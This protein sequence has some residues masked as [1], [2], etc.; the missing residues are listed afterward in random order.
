VAG[1]EPATE[2]TLVFTT[3]NF[4]SICA[5]KSSSSEPL[6]KPTPENPSF[7]RAGSVGMISAIFSTW[8]RVGSVL[9]EGVSSQGVENNVQVVHSLFK[10]SILIIDNV[11]GT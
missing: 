6:L 3:A 9:V 10:L 11:I 8:S 4:Y 7:F 2:V 1:F 5:I